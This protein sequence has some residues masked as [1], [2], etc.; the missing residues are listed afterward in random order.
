VYKIKESTY[1][2]SSS[3]SEPVS[4]PPNLLL[5][6]ALLLPAV[7]GGSFIFFLKNPNAPFF[8]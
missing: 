6:E 8:A 5:F 1:L 2:L 7:A 4:F 3:K